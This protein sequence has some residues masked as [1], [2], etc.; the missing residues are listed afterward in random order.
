LE[1]EAQGLAVLG[2]GAEFLLEFG[3]EEELVEG[4][5]GVDEVAKVGEA[6]VESVVSQQVADDLGVEVEGVGEERGGGVRLTVEVE[7]MVADQGCVGGK[8]I[9]LLQFVPSGRTQEV[10]GEIDSGMYGANV[11]LQVG[12]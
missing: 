2:N 8:V 3:V 9:A 6:G 5:G 11:V 4:E 1:V 10:K 12:V 7:E